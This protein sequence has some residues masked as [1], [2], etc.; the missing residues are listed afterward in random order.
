MKSSIGLPVTLIDKF[1][2]LIHL[3]FPNKLVEHLLTVEQL[4]INLSTFQTNSGDFRSSNYFE[5]GMSYFWL[6][7]PIFPFFNLIKKNFSRIQDQVFV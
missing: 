2:R 5:I 6:I 7:M 3:L 1:D 4:N